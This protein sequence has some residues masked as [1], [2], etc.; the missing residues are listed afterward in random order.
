MFSCADVPALTD[1]GSGR[2]AAT[3]SA[4]ALP[5]AA[6]RCGSPGEPSLRSEAA[7]PHEK[8]QHQRI[9]ARLCLLLSCP[10]AF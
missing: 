5:A 1:S 7:N 4:P 8:E 2:E 10:T 3:E 6:D 9:P